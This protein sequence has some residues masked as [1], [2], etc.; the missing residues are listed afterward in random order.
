MSNLEQELQKAANKMQIPSD[1]SEQVQQEIKKAAN[2]IEELI[3]KAREQAR[4]A[5]D[6]DGSDSG[7]CAAAWDA[8]EELQSEAS[9]Q[10]TAVPKNSLEKYCE[11]NPSASEC[12]I[13]DD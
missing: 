1:I 6:T 10:R 12:L 4:A 7:K 3:E 11:D 2:N 5:C 8:V 9:H 13:Y